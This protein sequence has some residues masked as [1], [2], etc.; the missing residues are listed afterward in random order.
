MCLKSK[1]IR[2][3][4][5]TG[6]VGVQ[7]HP[8]QPRSYG[9]SFNLF[10]ALVIGVV[11]DSVRPRTA[12]GQIAFELPFVVGYRHVSPPAELRL[13][14]NHTRSLGL[15]ISWFLSLPLIDDF[16]LW[17]NP[18]TDSVMPSCPPTEAVGSWFL[19]YGGI[20]FILSGEEISIAAMRHGFDDPMAVLNFV[21]SPSIH[22]SW[23]HTEH[24]VSS[25][26]CC[27]LLRRLLGISGA[28]S[29]RLGQAAR[30]SEC[31]AHICER[32]TA[33]SPL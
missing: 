25:D 15:L 21:S 31:D 1:S 11:S 13:S 26:R 14:S 3:F 30:Y 24:K 7:P 29:Q 33:V 20:V 10:P 32:L 27:N 2:R 5:T 6:S 23:S 28:G 16:F 17:L 8:E 12:R 9:S 22:N 18:P 19:A 4:L